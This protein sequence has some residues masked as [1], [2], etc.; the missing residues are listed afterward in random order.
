MER[1]SNSRG[2]GNQFIIFYDENLYRHELKSE[3]GVLCVIM[4]IHYVLFVHSIVTHISE[5]VP[6]TC[7]QST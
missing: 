6:V 1:Y 5:T 4:F 7:I 2:V 3:E